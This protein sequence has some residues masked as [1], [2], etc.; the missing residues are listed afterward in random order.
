MTGWH[1]GTLVSF[2]IES[3]GVDVETA[4]IVTAALV[5]IDP[6][7]G[8]KN[9]RDWLVDP[10]IEIPAEATAVH[11]VTT[12]DAREY[13]V[14]AADA[15]Y[16]IAHAIDAGY[17][18]G[19]TLIVYNAPYDLTVLDREMTRHGID[20]GPG[21]MVLGPVVD[22][23]CLDKHF[24]RYRKGSRK[25]VNV[26]KHYG[27]DLS[28]EDAHGAF[29][30]ALAAARVAWKLARVYP[31]LAAMTHEQLYAAQAGWYREQQ[32]SLAEYFARQGKTEPVNTEWP[33]RARI[34]AVA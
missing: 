32:A 6:V 23:L 4:R 13:G 21:T 15:V 25:L 34:E 12:E 22:P 28:E 29:A 19:G 11:G 8:Q 5:T 10:G 17:T 3:T 7:T 30:D 33:V 1:E 26:A 9:T 14:P 18:N 16:E 20:V 24:D 31:Q 27:V 2:D